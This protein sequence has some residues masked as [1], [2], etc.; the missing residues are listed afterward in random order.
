MALLN[1]QETVQQVA[2]AITASIELETEI[3]DQDLMIVGGTGRYKKKIGTFEEDGNL[4]SDS[5]YA[6]CITQGKEYINFHSLNDEHYDAKEGELAEICCPIKAED[7]VLGLIG[8]IA[9]TES[10]RELLIKKSSELL[11][12]L[13]IM[14]EL[15]AGKYIV[16]Q[17]N[18]S[19]QKTVSSLLSN[20]DNFASFENI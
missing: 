16:S 1:I 20:A 5:V 7:T 8:L 11:N 12:F 18:I 10:Q 17:I 13:R 9:L 6:T 3:V 2:D 14:S 19:L 15:I 4:N